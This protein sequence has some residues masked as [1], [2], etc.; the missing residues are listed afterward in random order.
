[1][2]SMV[3]FILL[4]AG[5]YV[6]L[7][8]FLIFVVR[9]S[10]VLGIKL[11][12]ISLSFKIHAMFYPGLIITLLLSSLLNT[13]WIFHPDCWPQ[14]LFPAVWI[15]GTA[16]S[17]SFRWSFWTPCIFFQCTCWSIFCW[18]PKGDFYRSTGFSVHRSLLFSTVLCGYETP[19]FAWI[20]HSAP[21]TQG[22]CQAP[23]RFSFSFPCPGTSLKM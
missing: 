3:H 23:Y 12:F 2:P 5:H 17:N 6:L 14:A 22:M 10:K 9:C 13:P 8:T 11:I 21:S 15:Q 19:R 18:I 20:L 4:C 1:M 7:K 16:L